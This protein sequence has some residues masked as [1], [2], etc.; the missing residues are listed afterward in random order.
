MNL[1]DRNVI[2]DIILTNRDF[3]DINPLICGEEKCGTFQRYG[4]SVRYYYLIHYVV[5]GRGTF[6]AGGALHEV[7]SGQIFIIRPDEYTTYAA[8]RHDPWHYRFVGFESSLDLSASLYAP[9]ITIPESSYIFFSIVRDSDIGMG[10]EWYIC[11]KIFELL[12]ILNKNTDCCLKRDQRLV[13]LAKGIIETKYQGRLTVNYI[14]KE[15]NLDRSHFSKVFRKVVG[16]SP[17]QYL[18]NYR[19]YK[20]AELMTLRDFPP[21]E[22]ATYVGYNDISNF[23]KMFTR[24]FGVPPSLYRKRARDECAPNGGGVAVE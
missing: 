19:L 17:Q 24:K 5:S 1:R 14:A 23:S 3:K 13:Q 12:A 10:R 11:G 16:K 21:G 15:L 22:A 9:V 20:A 7:E 18:V 2:F 8:C 4:P 6:E